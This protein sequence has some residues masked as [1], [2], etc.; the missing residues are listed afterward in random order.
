M[1]YKFKDEK[2]ETSMEV[3]A[4]RETAQITFH[5]PSEDSGLDFCAEELQKLINAL[6]AVAAEI[7][8][9]KEKIERNY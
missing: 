8:E 5:G 2:Q 3:E 9:H 6:Q 7:K 4:V 1:I